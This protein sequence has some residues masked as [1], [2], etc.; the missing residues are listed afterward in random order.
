MDD[1]ALF[2]LQSRL[3]L[4]CPFVG[5]LHGHLH[6]LRRRFPSQRV[7]L[8][9]QKEQGVRRRSY[10]HHRSPRYDSTP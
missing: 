9:Q 5:H 3:G 6:A 7:R 8:Q 1:P 2:A 4:D 10:R